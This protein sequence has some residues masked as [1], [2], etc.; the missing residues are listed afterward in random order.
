MVQ[1]TS[2][3]LLLA[4]VAV[5]SA[6]AAP[7][8]AYAQGRLPVPGGDGLVV[9]VS[10]A[11]RAD[12]TYLLRCHPG[13]GSHPD[14]ADAC[15]ALDRRTIWGRDPFAPVPPRSLC[16]MQYGGPATAHVTGT[17]AGRPVDA[18]YDRSDGCQVARWDDLV[19]L[20]PTV[21]PWGPPR[22]ATAGSG[23]RHW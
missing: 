16:T 4:A 3:G 6:A 1:I 12:G 2:R 10:H 15:D 9:T 19:P 7:P 11:G 8:V 17:W 13:R 22:R 5:L 23:V 14:P 21:R 20:L 18:R